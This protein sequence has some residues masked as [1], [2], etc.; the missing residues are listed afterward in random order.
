MVLVVPGAS[1]FPFCVSYLIMIVATTKGCLHGMVL[2]SFFD[3]MVMLLKELGPCW[4]F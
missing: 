1:R 4:F 2:L 3:D